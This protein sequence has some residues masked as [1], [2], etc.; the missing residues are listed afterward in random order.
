LK[1]LLD[2]HIWRRSLQDPARLGRRVLHE[3]RGLGKRT[4]ALSHRTWEALML[5]AKGSLR[6]PADVALWV[7][8]A[9]APLREAP[10][11]RETVSKG[12][13]VDVTVQRSGRSLPGGHGTLA[14]SDVGHCSPA[15]TG[16]DFDPREPLTPRQRLYNPPPSERSD[17]GRRHEIFPNQD[18]VPALRRFPRHAHRGSMPHATVTEVTLCP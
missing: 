1:L 10:L 17:P 6:L 15:G 9:T 16:R 14:R 4:L 2:T 3:L 18:A 5:N 13:A 12:P 7:A 11:T 8:Q